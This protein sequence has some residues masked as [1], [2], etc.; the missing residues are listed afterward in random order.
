MFPNNEEPTRINDKI[1]SKQIK[2]LLK[3]GE[4]FNGLTKVKLQKH[5]AI[6]LPP[7]PIII[8]PSMPSKAS[9]AG[10]PDLNSQVT[11]NTTV[12]VR[13]KADLKKDYRCNESSVWIK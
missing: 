12:Q 7:R 5:F 8:G 3:E 11:N 1:N 10:N 6:Q 9:P 13:D 4:I 2:K